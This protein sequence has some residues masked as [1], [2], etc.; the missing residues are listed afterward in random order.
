MV[1]ALLFERMRERAHHVLLTDERGEIARAP[2][3]GE[4]L[5]THAADC[6]KARWISDVLSEGSN[7]VRAE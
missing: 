6:S 2:L 5:I 4:H 3:A 7:M 1:Q